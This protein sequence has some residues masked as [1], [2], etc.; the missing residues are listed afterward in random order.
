[1]PIA[2]VTSAVDCAFDGGERKNVYDTFSAKLTERRR[3]PFPLLR[4]GLMALFPGASGGFFGVAGRSA[5]SLSG[6]SESSAGVVNCEDDS[7]GVFTV[8]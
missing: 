6:S 8:E 1:M 5:K 4:T 2:G 7:S 3:F